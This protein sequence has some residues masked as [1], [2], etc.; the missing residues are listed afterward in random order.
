MIRSAC[1]GIIFDIHS[2]SLS[3]YDIDEHLATCP[4]LCMIEDALFFRHK[5]L[6]F[7]VSPC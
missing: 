7:K 5:C 2:N 1:V 6:P 4:I 3:P